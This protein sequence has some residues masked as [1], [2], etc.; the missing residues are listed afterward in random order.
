MKLVW[1]YQKYMQSCE[2]KL[3]QKR[4]LARRMTAHDRVQWRVLVFEVFN[5]RMFLPESWDT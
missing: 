2:L 1:E 3:L 4:S 5:V